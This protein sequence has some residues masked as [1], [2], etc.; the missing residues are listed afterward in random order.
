MHKKTNIHAMDPATERQLE[1]QLIKPLAEKMIESMPASPLESHKHKYKR[2]CEQLR[3]SYGNYQQFFVQAGQLLRD[4]GFTWDLEQTRL[5]ALIKH[6]QE[7]MQELFEKGETLQD[8]LKLSEEELGQIYAIAKEHYER[9]HYEN[10]RSIFLLLTA[11]RPDAAVFY[12]GLGMTEQQCGHY[13][14]AAQFY[15][16]AADLDSDEPSV[17]LYAAQ[18]LHLQHRTQEAIQVLDALVEALDH[19]SEWQSLKAQA[20]ELKKTWSHTGKVSKK[21]H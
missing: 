18:C 16:L 14:T 10:A 19:E 12:A 7:G 5:N 17:Y 3:A 11:L 20:V 13:D 1:E 4:A 2:V 9:K 21:T 15:A 8:V 6:P